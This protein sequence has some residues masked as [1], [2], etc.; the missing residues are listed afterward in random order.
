MCINGKNCVR[1]LSLHKKL[2]HFEIQ[3]VVKFIS[4]VFSC[5]VTHYELLTGYKVFCVGGSKTKSVL[6]FP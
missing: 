1:F 4:P 2:F 3:N 5:C 6:Y